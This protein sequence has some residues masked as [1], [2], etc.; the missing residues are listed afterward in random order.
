MRD[1]AR[2]L[3]AAVF[4]WNAVAPASLL[5]ATRSMEL[6]SAPKS[7]P[8]ITAA[9]SVR[10]GP[11][12]I[13]PVA[14]AGSLT[15]ALAAPA[16]PTAASVKTVALPQAA[17]QAQA[18]L[19]QAQASLRA[20]S[21]LTVAAAQPKASAGDL[22]AQ[23]AAA[24]DASGLGVS[25]ADVAGLYANASPTLAPS[26]RA[27]GSA[28]KVVPAPKSASLSSRAPSWLP[29]A[30]MA[31]GVVAV[32]AVAH[33]TN[34]PELLT[35]IPFLAAG[36]IKDNPD[37]A[38]RSLLK[39]IT[40]KHQPGRVLSPGDILEAA[41]TA[42]ISQAD[43]YGLLTDLGAQGRFAL[44][45]NAHVL[46]LDLSYEPQDSTLAAIAKDARAGLLALNGEDKDERLRSLARIQNAYQRY[47]ARILEV[48]E[49]SEQAKEQRR[50]LGALTANAALEILRDASTD[51]SERVSAQKNGGNAQN[52]N[53][54]RLIEEFL[55]S[56]N[57]D[58]LRTIKRADSGTHTLLTAV[59]GHYLDERA[60][61]DAE[62]VVA[63]TLLKKFVANLSSTDDPQVQ[64]VASDL[65]GWLIAH[66]DP[67]NVLDETDLRT[68]A[69]AHSTD[70]DTVKDA[71]RSLVGEGRV[72]WLNQGRTVI[73]AGGA[74]R[75]QS[76][77]A[78]DGLKAARGNML[79]ALKLLEGNG[80]I[81][82]TALAVYA[83][84]NALLGYEELDVID[85]DVADVHVIYE[86]ALLAL[87]AETADLQSRLTD[88]ASEKGKLQRI[89]EWA[90]TH[91]ARLGTPAPA[92]DAASRQ[93]V[94]SFLAGLRPDSYQL[95]QKHAKE[96]AGGFALLRDYVKSPA[97]HMETLGNAPDKPVA[98][99]A[100][101]NTGG[102][103]KLLPAATSSGSSNVQKTSTPSGWQALEK[104]E[105]FKNLYTYGINVTLQAANNELKPLIGREE[106]MRQVIK[107]L[108]REEKNNP[109]LYGEPGVGKTVMIDGLAQKIVK[110][111]VPA[112]LKGANIVKLSLTKLVAGT[113][114]R[115]EFEER[116][117]NI[118]TELQSSK[119]PV[120]L[121][122][123]E[124]HKILGAG[125]A[126]G[127]TDLS[128][129]L[130]ENLGRPGLY[131][132]GATITPRYKKIEGNADLNR[133]FNGIQLAPPNPKDAV[134]ILKGLRH[135]YEKKHKVTIPDATLE[136]AVKQ[137]VR[138]ITDRALPDS[139]L[140]L[141]DDASTEV[142]LLAEE[143]RAKG[144]T[145]RTEVVLE[146][147]NREIALRMKIP[148][149]TLSADE[150]TKLLGM[151]DALNAK[152]VGQEDAVKAVVKAERRSRLGYKDPKQPDSYMFLGPTGVGKTELAKK[153]ALE[154]YGSETAFTRI[155]MS[156]FM[157][158]H[159]VSRLVGAPP[160]YVGFEQGGQ[161]T[162][163]VRRKP[164]QIVL[165]DE[166]DK[167]HP[168]VFNIL[169][170]AIEDG[171]LTDSTGRK[172]DFKHVTLIMTANFLGAHSSTEQ[173]Q[174]T[175]LGF[176]T[177]APEK[178]AEPT[179]EEKAAAMREKYIA[180]IKA[181]LRPELINRIG[182]RRVIV[183]NELSPEDLSLIVDIKEKELNERLADKRMTIKFTQAVKDFVIADATKPE[184]KAYGARPVKQAIEEELVDALADA[185]LNGSIDNGD[186]IL[187]DYDAANKRWI[188]TK[189]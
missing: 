170:Q 54:V 34:S 42:G 78:N 102:E 40:A 6:P 172:V 175:P 13:A 133:R 176:G 9:L 143:A 17:A 136:A 167:A 155:D 35:A 10:T 137:A 173:Q 56:N 180:D 152:V 145:P 183:F 88:S 36:T 55:H 169:L 73:V 22:K 159:S 139:A 182:L 165:L 112:E 122:I 84:N 5:A 49:P 144:E 179:R 171:H 101:G 41:K 149:S 15:G 113:K 28:K 131:V 64:K 26:H 151:E 92:M 67:G 62:T 7:V 160:G 60:S 156:E 20:A 66:K 86:N 150:K 83:L 72:A 48:T 127:A 32:G 63:R 50:Q 29:K 11:S 125:G 96:T 124:I 105:K 117:Q 103:R 82:D 51:L 39:A 135:R 33:W 59:A 118:L 123:D 44:L 109:L 181:K 158:K 68:I 164:H 141:L 153:M 186:D 12:L 2:F 154:R 87:V 77:L 23:A 177:H 98:A 114:Y 140:D 76:E 38:R 100:D 97:T 187:A 166:I 45:S 21:T 148:V 189:K 119:T 130:M 74:Q 4:A 16:L 116:V 1:T 3:L 46:L 126:E 37:A 14:V 71:L 108:L 43:A 121:F 52:R 30:L 110:G 132:I 61:T 161:L 91:P 25:A 47:S 128:Q 81:G 90:R 188:I 134:A 146:D 99:S 27:A 19:P 58:S 147:V 85:S 185:D 80:G 79:A 111:D 8:S 31:A 115:G 69:Q 138:F 120:I 94:L 53:T 174:R 93:A 24:F 184:N 89:A 162:D 75:R 104:G 142:Q 65:K 168:D 178:K 106:E 57:P 129:M 18:Q 157:E 70:V 163:A 95:R 107:T